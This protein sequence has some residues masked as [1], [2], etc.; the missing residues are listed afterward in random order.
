MVVADCWL[1]HVSRIRRP[2][3]CLILLENLEQLSLWRNLGLTCPRLR[4]EVKLLGDWGS[5]CDL[6][7]SVHRGESP[8]QT[9]KGLSS[10]L[11]PG[12]EQLARTEERRTWC[13]AGAGRRRRHPHDSWSVGVLTHP[14]VRHDPVNVSSLC[15]SQK[16]RVPLR[17]WTVESRSASPFLLDREGDVRRGAGSTCV[18]ADK[19]Q[20]GCKLLSSPSPPRGGVWGNEPWVSIELP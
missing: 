18:P 14:L 7:I 1:A 4:R 20:E 15:Q 9:K 11:I 5:S 8:Q 10:S 12:L 19:P 16:Q 2:K 3:E 6:G 17:E 13:C